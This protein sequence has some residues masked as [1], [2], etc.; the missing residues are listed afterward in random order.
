MAKWG[1]VTH[2]ALVPA[3]VIADACQGEHGK[4]DALGLV[5]QFLREGGVELNALDMQIVGI[6]VHRQVHRAG[7]AGENHVDLHLGEVLRLADL[8]LLGHQVP[9]ALIRVRLELEHM[10]GLGRFD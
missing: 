4:D 8:D 9:E 1:V 2:A 3:R 5:E 7:D 6:L 10:P